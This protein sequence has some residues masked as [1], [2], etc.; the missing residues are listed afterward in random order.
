MSI[1]A[2]IVALFVFNLV[3]TFIKVLYAYSLKNQ[4]FLQVYYEK[5]KSSPLPTPVLPSFQ[6][7]LISSLLADSLGIYPYIAKYNFLYNYSF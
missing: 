5:L 2:Y 4:L 1:H 3:F 7:Q 6:K